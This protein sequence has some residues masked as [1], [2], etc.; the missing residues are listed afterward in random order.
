MIKINLNDIPA[1]D[2]GFLP[3]KFDHIELFNARERVALEVLK[4]IVSIARDKE[5]AELYA[6]SAFLVAD[7]FIAKAK[8]SQ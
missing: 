7:A 2:T 5:I 1:D 4:I 8:E 6:N 3:K